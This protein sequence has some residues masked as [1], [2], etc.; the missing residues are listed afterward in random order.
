LAQKRLRASFF[1]LK[2]GGDVGYAGKFFT[3]ITV[4]LT[5]NIPQIQQFISDAVIEQ[6]EIV[7]R[8]VYAFLGS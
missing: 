6:N 4:Q 3:G 5:R 2:G 8:I 7:S 1:F